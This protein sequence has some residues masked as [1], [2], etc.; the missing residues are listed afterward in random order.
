MLLTLSACNLRKGPFVPNIEEIPSVSLSSAALLEA[1]RQYHLVESTHLEEVRDLQAHHADPRELA[2]EIVHRGWA[3]SYQMNQL[4]QGRA[5]ELLLGSYVLLEPLGEGGMG[6]AF[7]ARNWKLGKI[8]TLKRIRKQ[9]L[10]SANAVRRF[11]REVRAAAQL[12]HPNIVHAFDADEVDGIHLLIM[13]YIDGI[14]L[15]R[16]VKKHGPLPIEHACDVARQTAL[17]LQHAHERGLVHRDIKPHNL[18]LSPPQPPGSGIGTVK[19]LDMGLARLVQSS[20]SMSS[21]TQE[22]SLVGTP[23]Y[24]A[25]EQALESRHADIRSDLYSLGSTLYYLLTG[26]VPFPG[27]SIYEKMHK[28]QFVEPEPVER[29]RSDVP[30]WLADIVHRLLAKQPLDRFQSPAELV[31]ALTNR[32]TAPDTVEIQAKAT[33]ARSKSPTAIKIP[34]LVVVQGQVPQMIYPLHE[35]ANYIGRS[36]GQAIDVDLN[37]QDNPKQISVSRQHAVIMLTSGQL[38]I[39]DLGSTNG[40]QVNQ[41][42]LTPGSWH[43]LKENDVI[44]VGRIHLKLSL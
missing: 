39:Q 19:I 7:K 3:T 8:V 11:E 43:T 28:V 26:S 6:E 15:S 30:A 4:A 34:I 27:G 25:P 31:D 12:N 32:R 1:L 44:R 24:V 17:G 23:D 37:D 13:E 29:L 33:V 10:D 40:T 38:T 16:H 5:R 18:L 42:R 14:D 9:M 20:E 2:R 41:T 35:G 21:V 36:K 22:G